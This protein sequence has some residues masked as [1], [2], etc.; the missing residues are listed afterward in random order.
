MWTFLEDMKRISSMID[1]EIDRILSEIEDERLREASEH[2]L[3]SGGKRL[4]PFLVVISSQ[5]VGGT[6]KD[7][8]PGALAVELIH[9]FSLVHDDIMDRSKMR[10]GKP[11]VHEEFGEDMAIL[12]GDAIFSEAFSVLSSP[13]GNSERVLEAIKIL[14][15]TSKILCEG[16]SMDISF[17]K[18]ESVSEEEYLEMVKKKTG[19]LI[20]SSVY[21]GALLGGGNKT[22][23]ESLWKYGEN[24]GVAFQ[25]RDDWL[26]LKGDPGKSGKPRGSDIREGSKTIITIHA[27][28]SLRGDERDKLLRVLGREDISESE[29]QEV[30]RILEEAGS[31]SYAEEKAKEFAEKAKKYLEQ[32]EENK[33]R[34]YLE[35]IAD[36]SATREM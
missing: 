22:E 12:T 29:I 13:D 4:R 9:N 5:L 8:I 23:C 27:L 30:I 28:S 11:T 17:K 15:R 25:I 34:K 3:K 24:L 32:F 26:D 36:F 31:I 2:I 7:A 21:I 16:Q 18:R 6:V 1:S 19:A 10:R 35:E 14:S 33:Y 20:A